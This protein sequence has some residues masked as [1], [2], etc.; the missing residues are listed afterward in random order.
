MESKLEKRNNKEQS[1]EIK[2]ER[3][4]EKITEI[5]TKG[6]SGW[7]SGLALPSAHG[8]ILETWDRVSRRAPY[9][10]PASPSACVSAPTPCLLTLSLPIMN[11]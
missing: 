10:E 4:I 5:K 6:Q 1:N 2:I 8:I 7:F 9:R 3:A 11:K